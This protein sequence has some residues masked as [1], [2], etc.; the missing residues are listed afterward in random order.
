MRP[1]D[2][3][4]AP[5]PSS[6]LDK[7]IR[8][9]IKFIFLLTGEWAKDGTIKYYISDS[10][11]QS[12]INKVKTKSPDLKVLAWAYL[13]PGYHELVDLSSE[14][15]KQT[16]IEQTVACVQKGF[17]GFNDDVEGFLPDKAWNQIID[18]WNRQAKAVRD[19]GKIATNCIMPWPREWLTSVAPYVNTDYIVPMLYSNAPYPED[20]FKDIMHTILTKSASPVLIGMFVQSTTPI[21]RDQLGWIDPQ[22]AS[23]GPYP[24]LAGFSLYKYDRMRD[25]DWTDWNNWATK[26]L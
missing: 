17:D 11:I 23:S 25:V 21:L 24:K 8:G 19:L 20:P 26:D 13:I 12:F 15:I 1:G 2:L 22:I 18:Y 6:V 14:A 5:D 10:N 16:M 4:N 9:K 3:L 7:L